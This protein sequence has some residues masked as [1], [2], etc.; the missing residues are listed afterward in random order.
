MD[1]GT[2]GNKDRIPKS[3]IE[4]I[5]KMIIEAIPRTITE[6]KTIRIVSSSINFLI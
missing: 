2:M 5:P 1:R 3:I 4:A 6:P